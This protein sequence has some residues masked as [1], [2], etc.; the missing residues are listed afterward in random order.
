MSRGFL[1]IAKAVGPLPEAVKT[2]ILVMVRTARSRRDEGRRGSYR[3]YFSRTIVETCPAIGPRRTCLREFLGIFYP[4]ITALL[5]NV[6]AK[7]LKD[8]PENAPPA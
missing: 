8:E 4:E 2:G 5:D 7:H 3:G 6:E 1:E